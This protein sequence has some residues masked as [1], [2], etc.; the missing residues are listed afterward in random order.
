MRVG[1]GSAFLMLDWV[2][3]KVCKYAEMGKGRVVGYSDNHPNDENIIHFK[4]RR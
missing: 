4:N 3:R 1:A 2:Y